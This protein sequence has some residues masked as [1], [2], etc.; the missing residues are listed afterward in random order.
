MFDTAD[1]N[2]NGE[3]SLEEFKQFSLFT[4]EAFPGL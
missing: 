3:L 2:E 4:L 1:V